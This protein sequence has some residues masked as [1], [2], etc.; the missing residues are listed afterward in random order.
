MEL[1]TLKPQNRSGIRMRVDLYEKLKREIVDLVSSDEGV[2][3]DVFF[4]VLH[5]RFVDLLGEDVGWY[6]YH[7][8]L[9][10]E[11]RNVIKV[12]RSGHRRN[13]KTIIKMTPTYRT[14]RS[15]ITIL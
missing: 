8:K 11:T 15:T 14:I 2:A 6:I 5:D 10:L 1:V 9:D 7:V 13:K 12:V 4:A 3:L